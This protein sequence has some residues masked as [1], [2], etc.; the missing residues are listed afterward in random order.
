MSKAKP[1]SLKEGNLSKENYAKREK[2]EKM[3]KGDKQISRIPPDTL[4]QEGKEIYLIILENLS[5]DILNQTDE[6][7]IEVAADAIAN[8]RECRRDILENGLFTEYTNSAG[9]R[10]RDQSKAVL[11][12][13]KYS[14]IYK[15]Y[16]PELGLSPSARS[17]IAN[18][19][20]MD[21]QQK[22]KK[23]IMELLNEDDDE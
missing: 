17:K 8:M 15:K 9:V 2:M 19:A 12:Y 1:V 13:Q 23:T 20:N 21:V 7:T 4:S 16:I 10:N 22:E 5:P 11:I 18:L 14:E 6:Y 3:L